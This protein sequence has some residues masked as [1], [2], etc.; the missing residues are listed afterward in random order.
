MAR[1]KDLINKLILKIF[2]QT[3]KLGYEEEWWE[4][5]EASS[6]GYDLEENRKIFEKD[7]RLLTDIVR[8]RI[9][10]FN[11]TIKKLDKLNKKHG[12]S[13]GHGKGKKKGD[14]KR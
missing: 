5:E 11:D 9:K 7:T 1:V 8:R 3:V 13:K 14:N 10:K 2:K 12:K 4:K 6:D